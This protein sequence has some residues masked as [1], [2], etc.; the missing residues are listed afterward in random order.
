MNLPNGL[1]VVLAA[2]LVAAVPHGKGRLV[3]PHPSAAA[4]EALHVRGEGFAPGSV[5]LVLRGA[6]ATYEMASVTVGRDSAFALAWPVPADARSGAY[7]LVAVA[8]DGDEITRADVRI[9]EAARAPAHVGHGDESA[10]P[11]AHDAAAGARAGPMPLERTR[12]PAEWAVIVLL[13]VASAAGGWALL[14]RSGA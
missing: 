1:L 6:L 7:R 5:R 10:G 13:W 9:T 8:P 2:A 11:V 14:R 3:L 12:S 4:G